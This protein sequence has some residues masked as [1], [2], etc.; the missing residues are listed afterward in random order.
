M[1][2]EANTCTMRMP[3]L[4][5]SIPAL[6]I[7][8]AAQKAGTA[9]SQALL[10]GDV[11]AALSLLKRLTKPQQRKQK[12]GLLIPPDELLACEVQTLLLLAAVLA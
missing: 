8:P 9:Y 12:H 11:A 4:P 6:S 3:A 1:L 2:S 7:P 5:S 10:S